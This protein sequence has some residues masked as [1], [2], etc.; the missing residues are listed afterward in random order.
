[1]T[2][3]RRLN[4]RYTIEYRVDVNVTD[5]QALEVA[6]LKHAKK[7]WLEPGDV[8]GLAEE[9]ELIR[10]GPGAV[11]IELFN[12]DA[13]MEDISGIEVGLSEITTIPLV[14]P[15]PYDGPGSRK[16]PDEKQAR[17]KV[18]REIMAWAPAVTGI[19]FLFTISESEDELV[20]ERTS[21]EKTLWDE[22]FNLLKGLL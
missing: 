20:D 8:C 1:M 6:A 13:I 17:E 4:E 21:H 22:Q 11:I 9:L 5:A 16:H 14:Q 18:I 12:P 2:T 19:D 7:A 15:R 10:S 3:N